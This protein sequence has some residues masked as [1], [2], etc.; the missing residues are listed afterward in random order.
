MNLSHD[1]RAKLTMISVGKEVQM[2][3][4]DFLFLQ[5][6]LKC[7]GFYAGDLDGDV[8]P[9]TRAA[10]QAF[11]EESRLIAGERG[12]F[13][14]RSEK[15][16]LTLHPKAQELARVFLNSVADFQDLR[17]AGITL[18][19]ISGTRTYDEQAELF[20]QGRTKSGKIVTNAE[21][22]ESN[23]NFGLA[24][25]VGLFR[26]NEYLPESELYDAAGAIGKELGL[27]WGGDWTRLVDKP[28]FQLRTVMTLAQIR[29]KFEGGNTIV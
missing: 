24:W 18:K 4:N 21:P 15:N 12:R 6:F 28:H 27:E 14:E 7:I 11:E 29:E 16:I 17:V 22:G 23:H 8:G 1:R 3:G 13:D 2:F 26:G 25:D 19:I 9:L 20:A 5:R 10:L